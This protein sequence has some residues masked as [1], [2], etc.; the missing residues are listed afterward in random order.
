MLIDLW[1]FTR[2]PFERDAR[3]EHLLRQRGDFSDRH[4]AQIYGHRPSGHLVIRHIATDVA[5][6]KRTDF[7]LGQLTAVT[8]F[9]NETD[10]VHF[11]EKPLID[12]NRTLIRFYISGH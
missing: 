11:S 5:R 7:I 3:V 8:L 10:Y 2:G 12:A 1:R 9:R 6:N 4:S